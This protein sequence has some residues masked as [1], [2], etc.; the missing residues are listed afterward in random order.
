VKKALVIILAFCA[1][2]AAQD[3]PTVAVY[4]SGEDFG[5]RNKS[6][7][8][9]LLTSLV[10]SGRLRA[11]EQPVAFFDE[12][13]SLGA[14]TARNGAIDYER[15]GE[16]GRRYG[17]RFV[18]LA[19]ITAGTGTNRVSAQVVDLELL[20]V[21]A[22]GETESLLN[23]LAEATEAARRITAAL[24]G[25]APAAESSEPEAESITAPAAEPM[26]PAPE[27]A[28]ALTLN[29]PASAPQPTAVPAAEP[30]PP[31]Q[32][33]EIPNIAVYVTGEVSEEEK[34]AL[35]TRILASLVNSGRYKGVERSATFTAEIDK[36]MIK[37]M[38]GAIDD[39]QISEIGKQFG[40]K[41]ICIADI[42]PAYD[43]F[44]VSTRIVNV[45]TA[46]VLYIGEAFCPHKT[47][48]YIT[49]V[50]EQVVRKMFGQKLLPE[51]NDPSLVRI[52]AGA[53]AVFPGGLGGGVRWGNGEEI[54]MPYAG[55]G[56]Y[57]YVDA[58]YIEVMA[59]YY[60]A[61]GKWESANT[62]PNNLPDIQR[63]CLQLGALIKYPFGVGRTRYF[64][65]IGA[66]YDLSV[67]GTM[68]FPDG[69]HYVFNGKDGRLGTNALSAL[70]VQLGGGVDFDMSKSVYIR[71]EF[72]YG[73][74]TS[75]AN[76][77][78]VA[79]SAGDGQTTL[80]H[81]WTLKIGVGARFAEL[82]F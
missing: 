57:L 22:S 81:G 47:A 6:L 19:D 36:E 61:G 48:L 65:I 71:S 69:E 52:S 32:S 17:A 49:W 18:C 58:G 2:I 5:S 38:S 4:V 20:K 23:S 66:V 26:T 7:G 60:A 79:S 76:E 1:V 63:A 40:V 12:A 67:S 54:A 41:Y 46:E 62:D 78:D 75:N 72:L 39:D 35:G 74:R 27:P 37:Q 28:P 73:I 45:E 25:S 43:A 68:Q 21:V 33:G 42:T 53:G 50:S 34:R 31:A 64:P 14:V 51:P 44:Q 10:E 3:L 70:W 59:G 11:I 29:P 77:Q 9:L 8:R 15:F 80:G 30:E 82:R 56:A 55:V 16:I 13:A 24:Y